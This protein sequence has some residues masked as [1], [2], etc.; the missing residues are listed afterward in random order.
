M[1]INVSSSSHASPPV[2]PVKLGPSLPPTSYFNAES[3][4]DLQGMGFSSQRVKQA[5]LMFDGKFEP[6]LDWLLS[7]AD[8]EDS[9]PLQREDQALFDLAL[10]QYLQS[11]PE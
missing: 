1:P 2:T 3:L 8:P 10:A 7:L 5:L 4:A 6:A 9:V 11:H